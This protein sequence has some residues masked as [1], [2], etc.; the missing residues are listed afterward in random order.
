MAWESNDLRRSIRKYLS[1]LLDD[2]WT[3]RIERRE[4]RDEERPVAVVELGQEQDL[5]ARET[6]TQGEVETLHPVTINF[7]PAI[8]ESKGEDPPPDILRES[9]ANAEGL[10]T[11]VNR[12]I[13]FGLTVTTDLED[14]SK[15]HWAGPFRIP[16]YDFADTPL[17]G[18][19]REM[20]DDPHDV[21]AV[22]RESHSV[23][24]I[25]DREDLRRWTVVCEFQATME[26]PGRE[27]SPEETYEAEGLEGSFAGEP[28]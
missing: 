12:W 24:S 22:L 19:N 8:P 7:Y 17:T 23:E 18:E 2:T 14:G 1:A 21:V 28:G 4:V 15:R 6:I 3:I 20:T 16:L 5:R 25:Q 10:K 27:R 9:Q 11:L 26:Q 13:M